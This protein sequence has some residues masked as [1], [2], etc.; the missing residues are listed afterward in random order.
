MNHVLPEL[1]PLV[2]GD[3]MPGIGF[4]LGF[5]VLMDPGQAAILGSVGNH[6]WG[7]WASTKFWADPKEEIVGIFMTQYIPNDAYS[8][9]EDY[10]TLVYQAL[11]D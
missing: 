2:L 3:P 8:P 11:V 5:S 9:R 1:M 4:G 10:Y 7:G 6:G